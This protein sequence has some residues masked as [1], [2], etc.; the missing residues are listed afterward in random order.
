MPNYSQ[1]SQEM[2]RQMNSNGVE[3]MGRKKCGRERKSGEK[4]I[5]SEVDAKK[6]QITWQYS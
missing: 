2:Y 6:C 5:D 1:R 3:G 4:D